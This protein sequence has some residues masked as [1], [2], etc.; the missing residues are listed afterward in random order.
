MKKILMTMNLLLIREKSKE[1]VRK[2][3]NYCKN[4]KKRVK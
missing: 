4:K 2:R 3:I 1:I